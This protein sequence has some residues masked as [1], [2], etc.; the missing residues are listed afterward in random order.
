MTGRDSIEVFLEL[1]GFR[2]GLVLN[3]GF[4]SL[5]QQTTRDAAVW[6]HKLAAH[7]RCN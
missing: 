2:R 6:S 7:Q 1:L 3:F 5:P 4:F